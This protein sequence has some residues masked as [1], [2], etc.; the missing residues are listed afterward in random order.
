L[1]EYLLLIPSGQVESHWLRTRDEEWVWMGITSRQSDAHTELWAWG[2]RGMSLLIG[3]CEKGAWT[4]L[5]QDEP[6]RHCLF[7]EAI[8]RNQQGQ[9]FAWMTGIAGSI[10]ALMEEEHQLVAH[11][12][13]LKP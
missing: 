6:L 1:L 2:K 4:S 9:L 11:H 8:H 12:L 5:V 7:L 3:A 10:Q 13:P